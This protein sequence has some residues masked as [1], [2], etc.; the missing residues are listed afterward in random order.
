[1]TSRSG[2]ATL[3]DTELSSKRS[4]AVLPPVSRRIREAH[5]D[6]ALLVEGYRTV[7]TN[8]ASDGP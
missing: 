5:G 2:R 4:T 8:T 3:S 6:L 1:M 7:N